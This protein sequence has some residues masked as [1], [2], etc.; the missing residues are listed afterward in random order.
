M[1]EGRPLLFQAVS[2]SRLRFY[3]GEVR[4]GIAPARW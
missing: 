1:H 2:N 4:S 3:V